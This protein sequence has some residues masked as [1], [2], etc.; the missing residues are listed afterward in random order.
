VSAALG[1]GR[2]RLQAGTFD[3]VLASARAGDF[4]YVDPPYAP[5]STTAHF[6]S[7][8][9]GGFGP[10]DQERLR[11]VA[12]DL[13]RRGCWVLLSNSTAPDIRRLYAENRRARAAGL[14]AHEVPARR[15]INSRASA[16]GP[17]M[18]YLITNVAPGGRR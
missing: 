6:T 11:D 13:A 5:M 3:R 1:R 12:V 16:R 8:T 2:L 9:V 14:R 10:A 18:E 17:V 7:Y 4:I 15:A